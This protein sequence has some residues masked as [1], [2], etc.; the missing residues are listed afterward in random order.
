MIDPSLP[1]GQPSS[2]FQN[3]RS[4][5]P[6]KRGRPRKNPDATPQE[7]TVQA[8]PF[9]PDRCPSCGCT[10]YRVIVTIRHLATSGVHNGFAY[11]KV[12]WRRC[13]CKSG[14]CQQKFVRKFYRMIK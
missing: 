4:E 14:E 1:S 9:V 12:T 2:E 7:Q 3:S 11:N 5:Q 8:D 6:R 13:V 10:E